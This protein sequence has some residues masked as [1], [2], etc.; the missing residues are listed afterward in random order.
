MRKTYKLH[1][2]G[3]RSYEPQQKQR[4]NNRYWGWQVA[5]NLQAKLSAQG[6][7]GNCIEPHVDEQSEMVIKQSSSVN[8]SLKMPS[9][10]PQFFITPRTIA[11]RAN[12]ATVDTFN[13]LFICVP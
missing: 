8:L 7:L 10:Y 1:S 3:G 11:I 2:Q 6:V 13:L 12:S 9:H 4:S 5:H